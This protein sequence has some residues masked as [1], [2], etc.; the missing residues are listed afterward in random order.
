[1]SVEDRVRGAL[2]AADSYSPSPDLFAKVQRSIEEDRVRR[3]RVLRTLGS[4]AAWFATLAAWL[5][6]TSDRV[7]GT[8]VVPWW[9]IEAAA[10]F[11]MV[12]FVVVMGPV[13]RRFGE[14]YAGA[15]FAA[16]PATGDRF[17]G[18]IDI[19]YYLTVTAY[20]LMLAQVTPA[21]G[22]TGELLNAAMP[23]V[24]GLFLVAGVLH[25]LTIV[26]LPLIGLVF[27]SSWRRAQ[28]AALGAAAGTASPAAEAAD[29]VVRVIIWVGIGLV[30]TAVA[31]QV[32]LLVAAV[33]GG[34]VAD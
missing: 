13:I 3:A 15:V 9:S 7:E 14:R 27:S 23:K 10:D 8:W 30:G 17:L 28:R 21:P 12:S 16:H 4:G 22:P 29:R 5:L 33:I 31:I 34:G 19:A 1:M 11:I 20:I 2:R 24:A 26:A 32:L 6:L 25:G 18:L